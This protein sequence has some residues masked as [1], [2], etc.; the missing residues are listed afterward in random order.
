[1]TIQ[2]DRGL[3]HSIPHFPTSLAV[4]PERRNK[5]IKKHSSIL[6]SEDGTHNRRITI[7]PLNSSATLASSC[8]KVFHNFN[9]RILAEKEV[10]TLDLSTFI[11]SSIKKEMMER[12]EYICYLTF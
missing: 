2:Q 5:N 10:L 4:V 6:P 3:R 8:F 9:I 1:M 12:K 11:Y 7:T